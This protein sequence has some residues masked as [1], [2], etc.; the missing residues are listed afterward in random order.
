MD[1]CN[2]SKVWLRLV[3]GLAVLFVA[4]KLFYAVCDALDVPAVV[5]HGIIIAVSG[6]IEAYRWLR[7]MPRRWY[8]GV[9]IFGGT[10]AIIGFVKAF[11][12]TQDALLAVLCALV[13]LSSL[14]VVI[15]RLY[16]MKEWGNVD[17]VEA[18]SSWPAPS[19]SG[20]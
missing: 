11:E 14:A 1:G 15:V 17:M 20:S 10:V 4:L 16:C 12:M 18:S 3:A 9:L 7:G 6:C 2:K 13:A 8:D 5:Q 19:S